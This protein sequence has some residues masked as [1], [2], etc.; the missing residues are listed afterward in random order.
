M[1]T[2]AQPQV[3]TSKLRPST[4]GRKQNPEKK[5]SKQ[6]RKRASGKK[7]AALIE[8]W[9]LWS[10]HLQSRKQPA[11]WRKA[12]R[13][14]KQTPLLWATPG[15]A[16]E[17]AN[18]VEALQRAAL[19]DRGAAELAEQLPPWLAEAE[20]RRAEPGFALECLAWCYALPQL[21]AVSDAS[22]WWRLVDQLLEIVAES[23]ALPVDQR[24]L[25]SQLLAGEL[26]LALAVL[27][28]EVERCRELES[29]ARK[30][31][32]RGP[33]ELLDTGL[34]RAGHL[35][36]HRPLLAC[37]T[38]SALLARQA[39][40]ALFRGKSAA[41][42]GGAVEQMLRLA[43]FD[44]GQA[45]VEGEAGRWSTD[46]F[47]AARTRFGDR[48]DKVRAALAVGV[49]KPPA[50][51]TERYPGKPSD[52]SEWGKA[53]ILRSNWDR[54]RESLVVTYDDRS[55]AMELNCGRETVWSGPLEARISVDG[56]SLAPTGDWEEVCW[57]ADRDV[58]Y[59]EL[60]IKLEKG[61]QLQ[62]QFILT[63][64]DRTLLVADSLIGRRAGAID[65][66]MSLPLAECVR[67]V[68]AEESNEGYLGVRDRLALV[69]PL[70]LPEWRHE[71]G[72]GELRGEDGRLTLGMQTSA[73][74][75][76]APLFFDLKP[77]RMTEPFTWRRLTV[78]ENLEIQR[79]DTAVGY[80]V[81]VGRRQWLLYRS[82]TPP[83]A[84]TLLGQHLSTEFYFGRF[85]Q[86]G[87]VEDLIEVE[88]D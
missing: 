81:Q 34:P 46:L 48:K 35:P 55:V 31:L 75:L 6:Q 79:P 45:L 11:A 13:G 64:E 87:E 23:A 68:P 41:Q 37:W 27:L 85:R 17:S 29:M 67:F 15:M 5:K 62:R 26:P 39:G 73:A 86:D 4:N 49:G 9:S 51:K 69:L 36:L 58:D 2:T 28:P 10:E 32:R 78:A 12:F 52:H 72:P 22:T 24:P 50:R 57:C 53:A 25:E 38:R 84:R 88:T 70:A 59:L 21:A 3:E 7:A 77:S 20:A 30:A 83:T 66:Q 14:T 82:L 54:R 65:Y 80:R 8:D 19:K 61:W 43:R 18:L 47:E 42:L 71:R 44:G 56:E 63:R 16:P 76:Y 60:E 74:A 1:S 33:Q 40:E